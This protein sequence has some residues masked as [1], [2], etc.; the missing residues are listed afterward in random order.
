M[1]VISFLACLFWKEC[2][3]VLNQFRPCLF[4]LYLFVNNWGEQFHR[5]EKALPGTLTKKEAI[6]HLLSPTRC[7]KR[8]ISAYFLNLHQLT[9]S[10]LLLDQIVGKCNPIFKQLQILERHLNKQK[11]RSQRNSNSLQH[12]KSHDIVTTPHENNRFV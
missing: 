2:E 5:R 7:S 6:D 3:K 8:F 4:C 12:S 10:T 11:A 9:T 1:N